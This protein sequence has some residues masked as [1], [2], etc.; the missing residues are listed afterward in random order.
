[1]AELIV[2]PSHVV[3]PRGKDAVAAL[4]FCTACFGCDCHSKTVLAAPCIPST[5]T[6][7]PKKDKK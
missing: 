1:M 3:I 6:P 7:R 4:I 2:D 5:P